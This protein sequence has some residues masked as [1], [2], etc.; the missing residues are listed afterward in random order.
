MKIIRFALILSMLGNI[1][2]AAEIKMYGKETYGY[3]QPKYL[4]RS[5]EQEKRGV[6]R[7]FA[8]ADYDNFPIASYE[9]GSVF[10]KIF[11]DMEDA[12][13]VKISLV[14]NK[15]E[16][17]IKSFERGEI[18][19]G[20]NTRARF[21]VYFEDYPYSKNEYV[22]PAFFENRIHLIMST[23]N[24]LSLKGKQ[25]LKNYKGVF[26]KAD[27][28][29]SYVLKDFSS[30]GLEKV[31]DF[32]TA[33]EYL[34]TGKADYI[35]ASYYLSEIE[36]YKQGVRNY[37][38]Y[39]KVP[40]W[41]MPMFIRILPQLENDESINKLKKYLKSERYQKI[42]EDVFAELMEIYRENTRGIVP[43]TY[44]HSSSFENDDAEDWEE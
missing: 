15:D 39:S 22:Y 4:E 40:V 38:V 24:K 5:V 12:I 9:Q 35:A 29:P 26:V 19:G 14:Y 32:Y 16:D 31:D 13:N 8:L 33:F 18:I 25:S 17:R 37:I 21:G 1:S 30:L 41:K 44:T 20:D 28:L 42:K 27:K 2:N 43:P 36:S 3:E 23:R 10:N 11:R 6:F 34:L 7:L